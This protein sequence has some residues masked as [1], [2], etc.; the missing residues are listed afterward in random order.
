[1][2]EKKVTTVFMVILNNDGSFQA[3][4]EQPETPIEVERQATVGD[5]LHTSRMIVREI[6]LQE[7]TGRVVDTFVNLLQAS[8]PAT[9]ADAIKDALKERGIQPESSVTSE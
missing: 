6:E 8:Q 4:L 2:S 1:M 9:P 7:L 5:V 3:Q